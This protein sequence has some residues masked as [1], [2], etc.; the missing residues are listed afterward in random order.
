MEC[1][2]DLPSL[3]IHLYLVCN[4]RTLM[5]SYNDLSEKYLQVTLWRKG[6]AK[7][8]SYISSSLQY[9][10]TSSSSWLLEDLE[11]GVFLEA[12]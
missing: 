5:Y 2:I 9:V 12:F 10:L 7:L 6:K 8:R 11:D 1:Y 3:C 4:R